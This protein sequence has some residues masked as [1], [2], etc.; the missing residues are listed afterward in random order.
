MPQQPP[1][2]AGPEAGPAKPSAPGPKE[3]PGIAT[4][5]LPERKRDAARHPEGDAQPPEAVRTHDDVIAA[6]QQAVE[7][8][9]QPKRSG[10]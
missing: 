2:A 8:P 7:A 10:S 9:P 3:P 5:I 6:E 1:P 4:A